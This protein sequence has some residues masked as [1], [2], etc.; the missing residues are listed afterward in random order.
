MSKNFIAI[1]VETANPSRASICQIGFVHVRDA[2]LQDRGRISVN[3]ECDFHH[4]CIKRH[5]I[6][7]TDVEHEPTM[8]DLW[9]K[10]QT[11]TKDSVLVSH[12]GFDFQAFSK[13]AEKYG[14]PKLNARW[15]DSKEI[16]QAVWPNLLRYSLDYL[17]E[18]FGI[19]FR[20]HDALEDAVAAAK[21]VI[22]ALDKSNTD[23]EEWVKTLSHGGE[24]PRSAS[25]KI[26]YQSKQN[27]GG[28]SLRKEN[29]LF[30]GT[31][32]DRDGKRLTQAQ[33]R[34]LV[35]ACGGNPLEKKNKKSVTMFVVGEQSETALK[36]HDKSRKHRD[37]LKWIEQGQ[38]IEI[39]SAEDFF[40]GVGKTTQWDE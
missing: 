35:E 6:Q 12:S 29:V 14:L 11:Q 23:I 18:E 31:L 13:V 33:A 32:R 5:G 16:S 17:A 27:I 34:E 21:I 26:I 1:D 39:V 25:R 4:I 15:A 7:R 40:D 24:R 30:T 8:P 38:K 19:S 28:I 10:I 37:I 22:R 36:G 20:H 2:N 9:E 3:P